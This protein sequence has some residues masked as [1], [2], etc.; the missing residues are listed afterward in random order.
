MMTQ[1]VGLDNTE[2]ANNTESLHM[3]KTVTLKSRHDSYV[4]VAV[5]DVVQLQ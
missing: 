1:E 4:Y 3:N 2:S 5:L